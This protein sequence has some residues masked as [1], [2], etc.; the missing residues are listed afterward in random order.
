MTKLAL[1]EAE[2]YARSVVESKGKNDLTVFKDD[3]SPT[4]PGMSDILTI[5]V[6]EDTEQAYGIKITECLWADV[7]RAA[8][9]A[10]YGYAAMCSGDLPFAHFINSQIHL[11]LDGTIMEGKHYCVLRYFVKP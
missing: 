8:G 7:F 2:E 11:D 9:A 1:L 10:E 5:E 3:Y 4:T 6:M